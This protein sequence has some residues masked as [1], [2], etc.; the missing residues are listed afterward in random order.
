M[1]S[2]HFSQT[3][4]QFVR[5]AGWSIKFAEIAK[6]WAIA[7]VIFLAKNRLRIKCGGGWIRTTEYRSRG[8]YSPLQ[9]A[10]MRHPQKGFADSRN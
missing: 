7:E 9:L 2:P 8:S 5:N 10:A 6:F 1:P 3:H 4:G